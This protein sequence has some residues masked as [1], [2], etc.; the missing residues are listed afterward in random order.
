M[1]KAYIVVILITAIIILSII[2]YSQITEHFTVKDPMLIEIKKIIEPL[3]KDTVFTG[4]LSSLNNRNIMSEIT[5]H[6]GNRSYTINKHKIYLCLKD[7]NGN[8]YNKNMLVY[9][10]LHEIAHVINTEIGHTEEFHN[11][12][13][14]L[15]DIATKKNIYNPS[16]P[17]IQNYCHSE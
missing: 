13:E 11:I 5:L 8:Y 2:I 3:F 14:S 16:V 6:Q 12:F 1:N 9:V 17:V 7:D 4:N 10:V 15:L